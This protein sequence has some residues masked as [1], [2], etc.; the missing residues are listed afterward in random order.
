MIEEPVAHQGE[1]SPKDGDRQERSCERRSDGVWLVKPV[2][3][4]A[5]TL[6]AFVLGTLALAGACPFDPCCYPGGVLNLPKE[7]KCGPDGGR[8]A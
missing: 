6:L 8:V 2:V 7:V 1:A 5:V 3:M 4:F